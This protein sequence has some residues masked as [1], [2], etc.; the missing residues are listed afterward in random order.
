M[1]RRAVGQ[2]I[3]EDQDLYTVYHD[4]DKKFTVTKQKVTNGRFSFSNSVTTR[5][6]KRASWRPCGTSGRAL[7]R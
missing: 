6:P 7:R 2:K 5:T 1:D 3:E 4:V